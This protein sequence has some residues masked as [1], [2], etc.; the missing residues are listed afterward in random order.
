[1]YELCCETF[2]NTHL[3][4]QVQQLYKTP[5]SCLDTNFYFFKIRWFKKIVKRN[6]SGMILPSHQLAYQ[7]QNTKKFPILI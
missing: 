1:V 5:N 4:N 7:N 3:C 2:I 6:V